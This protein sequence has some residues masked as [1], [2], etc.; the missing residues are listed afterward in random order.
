[1]YLSQYHSVAIGLGSN[2]GDRCSLLR[3]AYGSLRRHLQDLRGSHIYRTAPV[4]L[5]NQPEFLNA[6]CVGR[7]RLTPHQLM[8]ELQHIE[9]LAHRRRGGPRFGP[10]TLD[11]DLLL[12]DDRIIEEDDVVVPHPR[13][14]QRPFVLVPLRE[15][16][17][18]WRV[19][20]A[21]GEAAP[22]VA[23]LAESV[24]REGVVETDWRLEETECNGD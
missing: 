12:Y 2:L 1:M 7:T 5:T 21:G 4:G 13:L 8:A 15:I 23:E 24:G 3:F 6:C 20:V 18:D 9:T 22:T 19:P 11:L 14:H 16:A 17:G 10:R